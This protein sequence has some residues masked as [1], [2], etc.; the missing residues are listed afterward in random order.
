MRFYR[1]LVAA[2]EQTATRTA[3]YHFHHWSPGSIKFF[4]DVFTENPMTQRQFYPAVYW[5]D[6]L[7]W[8]VQRMTGE[9]LTIADI[10]CG[11]GNLIECVR[12]ICRSG[13]IYGVDLS[14]ESLQIARARFGK[15]KRI[16]FKV[17]TLD[18]LPFEDRSVDLLTCTEVLEHTF[19]E[20]FERSFAEV[21][22][23]LKGGGY[24]LAS[25]PF[26]E[27][28]AF[29]CCPECGSVFTPYQHMVFEITH[30]RVSE[31][32]LRNNLELVDFYQSLDRS[33]PA[34][35]AKRVLKPMIMKRL[36]GLAKRLFPK[37]GVSGF[38]ARATS[39]P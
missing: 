26:N 30:E 20:T 22:R 37:D 19:P 12:R 9:P 24:Y 29:V 5:E 25:V 10:G 14:E 38:L 4:W 18:E 1:D 31:L 27:K 7:A 13:S 3:R 16:R 6:L 39:K 32:L 33:E 23:V 21:S 35:V 34:N 8:A 11:G 17:G 36:P 28:P 2:A 15:D